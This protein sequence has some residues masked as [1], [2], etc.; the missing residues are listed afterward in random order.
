M[1]ASELV[2]S[3]IIAIIRLYFK[4]SESL[5]FFPNT[6]EL[7]QTLSKEYKK[8][9]GNLCYGEY[10]TWEEIES[11]FLELRDVL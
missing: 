2:P 11:L 4:L 10:P 5:A 3:F 9:C 8:Q 7:R 1:T 6:Q